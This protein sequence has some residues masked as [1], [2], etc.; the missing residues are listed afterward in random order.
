[1]PPKYRFISYNYTL[2]QYSLNTYKKRG[3]IIYSTVELYQYQRSF[4]LLK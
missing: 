1:M 2:I 4:H 3:K